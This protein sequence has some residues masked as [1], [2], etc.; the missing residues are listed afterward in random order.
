MTADLL[1]ASHVVGYWRTAG[2]I[3]GF[4]VY[5]RAHVA[6]KSRADLEP[7]VADR[8]R[9]SAET[10]KITTIPAAFLRRDGR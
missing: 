6:A 9:R 2:L 7:A 8:V 5:G 3:R 4:I 1:E 10:R